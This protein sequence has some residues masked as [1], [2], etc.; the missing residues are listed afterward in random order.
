VTLALLAMYFFGGHAIHSFTA[1]ML[2]GVVLVGTYTS[3]FIA[4]P[5]LIYFG[6]GSFRGSTTTTEDE[7]EPEPAAARK[8]A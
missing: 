2:F 6:V 1:T 3:I 5:L 4:A 7:P 8:R